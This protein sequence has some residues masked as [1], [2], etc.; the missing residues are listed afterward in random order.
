M[1]WPA[2]WLGVANFVCGSLAVFL[3]IN[4]YNLLY[5]RSN[6]PINS[7]ESLGKR[8]QQHEVILAVIEA[9]AYEPMAIPTGGKKKIKEICLNR[10]RVFTQDGFEHAWKDGTKA[11]LFS[12]L[13]SEKF[14]SK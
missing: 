12:L 2:Y 5:P 8:G 7:T 14:S 1:T 13:E 11:S 6:N 10:V 4:S 9:L 3:L